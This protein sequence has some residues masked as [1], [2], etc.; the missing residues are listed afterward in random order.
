MT[1]EE[2]YKEW[3]SI[4][5]IF[6]TKEPKIYKHTEL[7]D[8]AEAYYEHRVNGDN[9]L[10]ITDTKGSGVGTTPPKVKLRPKQ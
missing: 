5:R 2:Y 3:G 10:Q 9:K 7:I 6:E 4:C 1:V 8:F